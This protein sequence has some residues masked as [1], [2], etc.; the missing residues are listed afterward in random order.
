MHPLKNKLQLSGIEVISEETIESYYGIF[1]VKLPS[2]EKCIVKL[3]NDELSKSFILKKQILGSIR[4]FEAERH[5]NIITPE[6]WHK[7]QHD[8]W[9]LKYRT[10]TP[11]SSTDIQCYLNDADLSL[12]LI[13]TI[14]KG[15]LFASSKEFVHGNITLDTI[16]LLEDGNPVLTDFGL[17]Q[18]ISFFIDNNQRLFIASR[19]H[20]ISPEV[21][22]GKPPTLRSDIYSLGVVLYQLLLGQ[23]P[24]QSSEETTGD[25]PAKVLLKQLNQPIPQLPRQLSDVQP[26]LDKMIAK[27]PDDRFQSYEP[28]LKQLS[29][30]LGPDEEEVDSSEA[31]TEKDRPNGSP[32][33][34]STETQDKYITERRKRSE[35][36]DADRI[37]RQHPTIHRRTALITLSF[38]AFSV[39]GVSLVSVFNQEDITGTTELETNRKPILSNTEKPESQNTVSDSNQRLT[40]AKQDSTELKYTEP[41]PAAIN[42]E[43]STPIKDQSVALRPIQPA[44][45]LDN[46]T[47]SKNIKVTPQDQPLDSSNEGTS[48]TA[49]TVSNELD[50]PTESPS[51]EADTSLTTSDSRPTEDIQKKKPDTAVA[52][53]AKLNEPKVNL[54]PTQDKYVSLR[55]SD[56]EQ[57][58]ART[59]SKINDYSDKYQFTKPD[60]L[61]V[62]YEYERF[63]EEYPDHSEMRSAFKN[64]PD[65]IIEIARNEMTEDSQLSLNLVE[66]VLYIQPENQ[67]AL[68]LLQEIM[69]RQSEDKWYD[70]TSDGFGVGDSM[71]TE[72]F[73]RQF[74]R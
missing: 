19:A 56:L 49:K 15:L 47:Q 73:L 18:A 16:Y 59:K 29:A 7:E 48:A 35:H 53:V 63:L 6:I 39:I 44:M 3:F 54:K 11:L 37:K 13:K 50:K 26:L 4:A 64:L 1:S 40:T 62:L 9:C 22:L 71:N 2:G 10:R 51:S 34:K 58:Y 69:V 68:Q 66:Q 45:P 30:L 21:V 42:V 52:Q 65:T 57:A 8:I 41:A 28:L 46:N 12:R 14:T 74:D 32:P 20:Y 33:P 5:P 24:Y 72:Q 43:S 25:R 36:K 31:S 38:I 55:P 67:Q 61:N 70:N 17:S 23:L 60:M 27:D